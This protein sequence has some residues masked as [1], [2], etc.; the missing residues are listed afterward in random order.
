MMTPREIV[1]ANLAH[2]GAERPGMDFTGARMRDFLWAGLGPSLTYAERRWTEGEFEYYTDEWGNL[3]RRI[4]GKSQQGEIHQPAI[5]DWRQLDTLAV[6]DYDDPRRFDGIR[7]AFA[8][9]TDLFKMVFIPGWVFATSRYLRK[10]E[11]YFE[12]LCEYPEEIDRLHGLVAALFERTI[13]QCGAAGAEGIFFCED[14]GTQDR[15]LIGPA[16]WRELYRPHYLRL[17]TA[18]H[19]AGMKVFMHSCGYNWALLD[20]LAGAGIDCFQFDQPATYDMP[21]LAAKLQ[22]L[23][24]GLWAPVDIQRVMPTGDR[25]YIEAEAARMVELFGGGLILKNY[26]DLHGIGVEEEWDEWAYRA[27][28]RA[29][30]IEG[31]EVKG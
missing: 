13:R 16:M 11:V 31:E 27:I 25:A 9:P 28:L 18:A 20:D 1:Y 15:L 26:T 23:K 29:A 6:P 10:M 22:E 17:T 5:T 12:D 8:E 7:T 4:V 2:A 19:E 24:V 3:W 30:E 21:A 14:L